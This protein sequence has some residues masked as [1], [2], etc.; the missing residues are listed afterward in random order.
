[1]SAAA[2]LAGIAPDVPIPPELPVEHIDAYIARV[3]QLVAAGGDAR[4][5]A[6][7]YSSSVRQ[8]RQAGVDPFDPSLGEPVDI[9]LQDVVH[10][11]ETGEGEPCAK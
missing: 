9:P 3:R 8:M 2:V 10:W 11:L 1:M 7:D 6:S 4:K 5:I